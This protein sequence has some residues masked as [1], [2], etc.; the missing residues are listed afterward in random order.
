[1]ST[2]KA[3]TI[4]TRAGGPVSLT[5]QSAAKFFSHVDMTIATPTIKGSMN[6]ASITDNG[7]G[8]HTLTFTNAMSNSGYA[9]CCGASTYSASAN[10][11][12]L[13]SNTHS[14]GSLR[15]QSWIYTF[16]ALT[17]LLDA[18]VTTFGTLA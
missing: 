4:E 18:S 5:K 12:L 3:D 16:G 17:D 8:D 9:H 15:V 7:A 6:L 10:P 14:T 13:N 11:G 2:L 1:M